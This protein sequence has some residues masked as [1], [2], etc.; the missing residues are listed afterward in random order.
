MSRQS[1]S[2]VM[3]CVT[4][5]SAAAY[6][7]PCVQRTTQ[8]TTLTEADTGN[9]IFGHDYLTKISMCLRTNRIPALVHFRCPSLRFCPHALNSVQALPVAADHGRLVE[10]ALFEVAV[11][12]AGTGAGAIV[13]IAAT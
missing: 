10:V 1:V 11:A 2:I 7:G 8:R 9:G 13:S 5:A 4:T 6:N 3:S 12:A